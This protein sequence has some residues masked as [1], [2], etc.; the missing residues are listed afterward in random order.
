[1]CVAPIRDAV[2]D[3]VQVCVRADEIGEESEQEA[4]AYDDE[5]RKRQGEA[6][7]GSRVEPRLERTAQ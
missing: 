1:V 5:E 2:V 6:G 7:R 3:S 4:A